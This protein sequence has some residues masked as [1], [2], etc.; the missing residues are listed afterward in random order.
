V[1]R[2]ELFCHLIYKSSKL[3]NQERSASLRKIVASTYSSSRFQ[4]TFSPTGLIQGHMTDPPPS[5]TPQES[6]SDRDQR[7]NP[8]STSKC[9]SLAKLTTPYHVRLYISDHIPTKTN[10]AQ[11]STPRQPRSRAKKPSNS[12]TPS[13]PQTTAQP[14]TPQFPQNQNHISVHSSNKKSTAKRLAPRYQAASTYPATKR[15]KPQLGPQIPTHQT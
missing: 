7:F 15:P 14:C 4:L 2:P 6:Q 8:Q 5:P 9:L 13:S 10:T 12:S 1:R 3:A 11:T